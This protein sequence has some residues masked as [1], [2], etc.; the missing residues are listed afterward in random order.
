MVKLLTI[1]LEA[2]G[3]KHPRSVQIAAREKHSHNSALPQN[4]VQ[5]YNSRAFAYFSVSNVLI[6]CSY[7]VFQCYTVPEID[8]RNAIL[9][10]TR[11]FF[12]FSF[13]A[14]AFQLS[15]VKVT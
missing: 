3:K 6:F 12:L 10:L 9:S 7:F 5:L 8:N 2:S 14:L 13:V 15:D 1:P 11:L 4:D